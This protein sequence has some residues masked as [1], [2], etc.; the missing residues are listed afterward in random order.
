MLKGLPASNSEER[1]DAIKRLCDHPNR[2]LPSAT[3]K[4]SCPYPG[5]IPF[6][7]N[8]SERFFGRDDKIEQLLVKL[9]SNPFLIVIGASGSGKSSL[10]FAGLIPKLKL[11]RIV[12]CRAVV[13]LFDASWDKSLS[14]P[15]S[16]FKR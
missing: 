6:S 7:E 8:D 13:Y 11:V 4:P 2:P 10:V 14:Q 3:T 9:R 15:P 5:M 12:W 1:E 16:C